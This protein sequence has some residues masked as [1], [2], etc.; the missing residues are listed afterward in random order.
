MIDYRTA[1]APRVVTVPWRISKALLLATSLAVFAVL[2]IVTFA[3]VLGHPAMVVG[4]GSMGDALPAGSLAITKPTAADDLRTGDIVTVR[5]RDASTP[6]THR[7]TEIEQ[8]GDGQILVT[9]KG[10]ANATPDPE[11]VLL[12]TSDEVHVV[13]GKIPWLGYLVDFIKTPLGWFTLVL[14]PAGIVFLM[15]IGS[16]WEKPRTRPSILTR[17]WRWL[18]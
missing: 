13:V 17:L 7:I 10:D 15:T 18:V 12:S 16:I 9:T 2:S 4:G 5:L 11:P 1:R 8:G 6:I 14:A 3:R